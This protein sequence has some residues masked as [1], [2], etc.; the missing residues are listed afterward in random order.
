MQAEM[1]LGTHS[2]FFVECSLPQIKTAIDETALISA[3]FLK[4]SLAENKTPSAPLAKEASLKTSLM[5]SLLSSGKQLLK[6]KCQNEH[7]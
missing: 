7:P 5:Q 6:Q 3:A 2:L 4:T 1:E